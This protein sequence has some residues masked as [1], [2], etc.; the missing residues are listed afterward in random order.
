VPDTTSGV[1]STSMFSP[2]KSSS[3]RRRAG[4]KPCAARRARP[5]AARSGASQAHKLQSGRSV[6]FSS[7]RFHRPNGQ[8]QRSDRT[9]G[10][11]KPGGSVTGHHQPRA[12]ELAIPDP[13]AKPSST[14]G[15]ATLSHWW[16]RLERPSFHVLSAKARYDAGTPFTQP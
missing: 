1:S 6:Y 11:I 14:P 2:I 10:W 15:A 13:K 16:I 12:A 7:G 3:S 5:E 8:T 9:Q 4:R